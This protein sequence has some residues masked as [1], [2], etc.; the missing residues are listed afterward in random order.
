MNITVTAAEPADSKLVADVVVPAADVDKAVAKAYRDFAGRYNFQGFRKGRAPRPVIDSMVGR[1]AVLA[2]A[3]NALLGEVE[4]MVLDQ[5]DVVPVGDLDYGEGLEPAAEK[6]DYAFQVVI[7]LIPEE[8]LSSYDAV[9][10]NMP[11]E[12]VTDAEIDQQLD[13]LMGYQTRFEDAEEGHAVEE[14]DFVTADVVDVENGEAFAGEGRMLATGAGMLPEAVE[15]ALVGMVPGEE[16]EVEF[17]QGEG[18]DAVDVKLKVKV[19]SIRVKV[20]PEL[21]DE[22]AKDVF[23]FDD[24]A[25]LRDAVSTEIE[26]E[27]KRAL[28]TL[29]EDRAV[30]ELETRLEV[31]ELPEAYVKQVHD[32]IARQ[33]VSDLQAQG[34]TVDSF[35]QM[36]RI[37]MDQLLADLDAQAA[38]HARQ[39]VALDALARHL[40]VQVTDDDVRQEFAD[41]YDDDKVDEAMAEFRSTG[42]MPAVRQT[43]RRSKALQWLLDNAEVTEVDEVAEQRAA[44]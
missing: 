21:T 3:T 9:A 13:V 34:Q 31:E 36:R 44:E 11:P 33:F 12:A 40:D 8:E 14:G 4:P 17:T 38:E 28:P 6:Q 42:Q 23:G 26:Q 29:K 1:D 32:E 5:L 37:G 16:K 15:A 43:I 18:D 30:R 27:K 22:Y 10:I 20:V 41:V 39:S 19:D 7:G 2:E 35:L 24:L 25:T